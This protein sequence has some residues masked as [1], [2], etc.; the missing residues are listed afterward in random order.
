MGG[1]Y[2]NASARTRMGHY[3]ARFMWLRIVK[4]NKLS[5]DGN[6]LLSVIQ[7]GEFPDQLRYSLLLMKDS[8]PQN[9]L[10]VLHFNFYFIPTNCTLIALYNFMLHLLCKRK[11]L[12]L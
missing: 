7:Y 8:A 6:E 1:Y 9:Y 10:T 3:T 5:E 12:Y 4:S 11:Y 2:K